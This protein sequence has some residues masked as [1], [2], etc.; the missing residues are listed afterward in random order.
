MTNLSSLQ[1]V[2]QQAI[3]E[4]RLGKPRFLRCLAQV[5]SAAKIE[6]TLSELASLADGWFGSESGASYRLG[7]GSGVYLTEMLRWSQGQGA[8]ITVSTEPSGSRPGLDLM[9]VGSRG[10]LYH[11]D[12]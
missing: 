11:E 9:L 3:D 5:S 1:Q 4:G 6:G 10:T 12:E 8:L 2:V 7:E